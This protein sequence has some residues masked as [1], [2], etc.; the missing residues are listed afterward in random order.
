MLV[1]IREESADT[2]SEYEKISIAFEVQSIFRVELIDRGLGGIKFFE[3]SVAPYIKAYDVFEKPS[4]WLNRFDLSNWGMLCA[5]AGGSR[6]GGAT[7]AWNT[8]GVEMLENKVDLAC[9]WDLRIDPKHRSKGVGHQLFARAVE[10]SR[11]RGCRTLK[12]ETQNINVP[13][14]KFYA[15]QDCELRLI[16]RRCYDECSN[17]IQLL[18]QKNI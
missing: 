12:V 10:W 17:E 7:I 9:L 3:E 6:V 8:P 16:D 13:A 11:Q 2:L 1:E 14:C 4:N 5:Y 18:W 15:R